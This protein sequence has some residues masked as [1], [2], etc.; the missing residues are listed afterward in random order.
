MKN[1]K[2]ICSEIKSMLK[3]DGWNIAMDK[4]EKI[5]AENSNLMLVSPE[6]YE[7]NKNAIQLIKEWLSDVVGELDMEENLKDDDFQ[8]YRYKQ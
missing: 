1:R 8:L 6:N 5:V 4:L 7:V 3:S 2:H